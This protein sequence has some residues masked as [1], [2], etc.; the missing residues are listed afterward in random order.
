[1]KPSFIGNACQSQ[2]ENVNLGGARMLNDSNKVH[3]HLKVCTN[4]IAFFV[5]IYKTYM[6]LFKCYSDFNVLILYLLFSAMLLCLNVIF[7]LCIMKSHI[8]C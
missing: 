6:L 8:G 5:D 3:E 7:D 1:M 4:S 2:E